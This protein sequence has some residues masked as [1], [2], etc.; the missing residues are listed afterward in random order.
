[1]ALEEMNTEEF[2]EIKPGDYVSLR[3]NPG[4]ADMQDMVVG[5]LYRVSE[6]VDERFIIEN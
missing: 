5:L 1:M 3:V 4:I 6:K 2:W